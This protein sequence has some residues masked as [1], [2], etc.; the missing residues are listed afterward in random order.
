[1]YLRHIPPLRSTGIVIIVTVTI[2]II[3]TEP[4]NCTKPAHYQQ[5]EIKYNVYIRREIYNISTVNYQ[6]C[7]NP[8]FAECTRTQ[9]ELLKLRF[10]TF[11]AHV[12]EVSIHSLKMQ[13][14]V[15]TPLIKVKDPLTDTWSPFHLNVKIFITHHTPV[16][17]GFSAGFLGALPWAAISL[18]VGGCTGSAGGVT[19]SSTGAST[20]SSSSPP[21]GS[22]K[23][24]FIAGWDK[25]C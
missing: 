9:Y 13:K 8:H 22:A 11:K 24:V 1:M 3:L 18:R 19:I 25:E 23:N 12:S 4:T 14:S 15:L 16:Y 6:R 5:L 21:R 17:L 2:R 7:V 20:T 10:K